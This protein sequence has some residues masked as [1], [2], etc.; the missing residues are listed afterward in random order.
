MRDRDSPPRARDTRLPCAARRRT[1]RSGEIASTPRATARPCVIEDSLALDDGA[2][3]ED[4][5]PTSTRR[6]IGEK[7]DEGGAFIHSGALTAAFTRCASG[8]TE[9]AIGRRAV[10]DRDIATSFDDQDFNGWFDEAAIEQ[11]RAW[12]SKRSSLT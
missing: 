5:N 11:T 10:S 6:A 3:L 2:S 8:G 7:R 4:E 12:S 1:R 9:R